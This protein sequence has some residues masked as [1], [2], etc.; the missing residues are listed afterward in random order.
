MKNLAFYA[1]SQKGGGYDIISFF[2]TYSREKKYNLYLNYKTYDVDIFG[3][4]PREVSRE[5]FNKLLCSYIKAEEYDLSHYDPEN[6]ERFYRDSLHSEDDVDLIEINH[7]K[8][9]YV[10]G[11]G[12]DDRCTDGYDIIGNEIYST[13]VSSVVFGAILSGLKSKGFEEVEAFDDY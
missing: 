6:Y 8:G 1:K 4:T 9:Q 11:Y 3:E 2:Y 10:V 12:I 13:Y 5:D 7:V